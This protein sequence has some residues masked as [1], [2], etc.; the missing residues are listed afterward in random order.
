VTHA[1]FE[2]QIRTTPV[3]MNLLAVFARPLIKWNHD[4]VMRR[5]GEALARMLNAR[6]VGIAHD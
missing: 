3:W 6:L 5:G 4:A 2:W 1:R